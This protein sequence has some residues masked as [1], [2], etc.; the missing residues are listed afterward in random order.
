LRTFSKKG[1]WSFEIRRERER[2]Y[3][4]YIFVKEKNNIYQDGIT[5]PLSTFSII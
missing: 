1:E 5:T 3:N 2:K 4:M